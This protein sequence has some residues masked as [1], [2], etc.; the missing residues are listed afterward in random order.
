MSYQWYFNKATIS[1]ATNNAYALTNAQVTNAGTYYVTIKNSGGTITSSNATLSVQVP[2]ITTQPVSQTNYLGSNATFTV[3]AQSDYPMTYQWYFNKVIQSGATNSDYP[4]VSIQATNAGAYYVIVGNAGGVVTSS[5]ATLTVQLPPP[6]IVTQPM[7]QTNYLGSNATFT[8]VAQSDY[9]M[10]YQWYFK[11]NKLASGTNTS[12]TVTAAQLTNAGAYS[13]VVTNVGGATTSSVATLTVQLPPPPLIVTQPMSQTNYL[14]SNA[15]F[16]VV[17]QSDYLM[18]Y[19]WYFKTNKLASGTNSI[20][21]ISAAQTTNAGAYFVVVT[22]VGGAT[23]SSVA[24]LTVQLPPAPLIVTQPMSQT[25]Y[26]GSNATFTVVAQSDYPMTYQWYFNKV[27]QSGATNSDYPFLS[28]QA[29]NAGPYYVIVR[30]AGGAVTSSVATLN[31]V[32]SPDYILDAP[33]SSADIGA[34]GLIGSAFSVSNLYTV[35]GSG[36]SL[37]GATPDQ[38][39]FVYQ[40]MNGDGSVETQVLSQSRTNVAGYAGIMIRESTA[41]G[42]RYMFVARQGNGPLVART[43]ASTGGSTASTNLVGLT[44]VSG[45]TLTNCWMKL[46]RSNNLFSS[47]ISTNGLNW[48][49]FAT[50]TIAMSTNVIFGPFVTSGNTNLLDSG[51]FTNI[52][53]VP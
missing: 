47:F 18:R 44:T 13:V 49:V 38:F 41:T 52:T 3:V 6:L 4:L 37:T 36:A 53:A 5:V 21:S 27:I 2:Q 51:A 23:T 39:R 16:T 10:R 34:V 42:S 26:L 25:N 45:S 1:G 28:A 11:T 7:S 33:W 17:A 50:N 40:L 19:Q 30:N 32:P 24:T 29:T 12:Y 35:N 9:L 46:S 14:G 15:T 48:T 8:V 22:N 43:R 20:Y 31:L